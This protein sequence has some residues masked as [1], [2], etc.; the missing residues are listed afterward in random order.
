MIFRNLNNIYV[1]VGDCVALW[2]CGNRITRISYESYD[3]VK[4]YRWCFSNGYVFNREVGFLHRFLLKPKDGLTCD[5]INQDKLDNR[6]DNL[7]EASPS[8]QNKNKREYVSHNLPRGI[9]KHSGG[10]CVPYVDKNIKHRK[11]F[12][13]SRF[14]TEEA[15]LEAAKKFKASRA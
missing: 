12:T 3:E 11:T 4:K 2:L 6:L 7:R 15:A 1:D 9:W 14:G 13:L 5:H 10:Y 8:L